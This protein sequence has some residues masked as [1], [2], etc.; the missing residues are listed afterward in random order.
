MKIIVV[1]CLIIYKARL[2][3]GKNE[4]SVLRVVSSS[5]GDMLLE[6]QTEMDI[7]EEVIQSFLNFWDLKNS[8]DNKEWG[9]ALE[10]VFKKNEFLTPDGK[11]VISD[12]VR[13]FFKAAGADGLMSLRMLDLF[14]MCKDDAKKIINKCDNALEVTKCFRFGIVQLDWAPEHNF[15][16][17]TRVHPDQIPEQVTDMVEAPQPTRRSSSNVWRRRLNRSNFRRLASYLRRVYCR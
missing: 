14:E 17:R 16:N 6:C 12:N 7:K 2:V 15:W 3:Q 13:E 4:V 11:T 8:A 1:V 9:C 10:C 5:I